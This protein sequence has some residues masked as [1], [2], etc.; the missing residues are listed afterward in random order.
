[1][2]AREDAVAP[3]ARGVT[4]GKAGTESGFP[5][6]R[7][8]ATAAAVDLVVTVVQAEAAA[9]EVKSR[10]PIEW[11]PPPAHFRWQPI[12][13]PAAQG[14]PGESA[15]SGGVAEQ[16]VSAARYRSTPTVG[17]GQSVPRVLRAPPALTESTGRQEQFPSHR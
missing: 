4:G 16:A 6:D 14:E 2:E 5:E 13:A 7:M 8:E 17:R 12:A 11:M 15:V 9:M 3:A 1:M 10:S